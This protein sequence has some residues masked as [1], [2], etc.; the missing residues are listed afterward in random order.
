MELS[1]KAEEILEGLWV[2]L[3]SGIK[4]PQEL[5]AL[6]DDAA[7]KEL[8]KLGYVNATAET[9][10]LAEKG[11][12][13]AENSIRRHRLAERLMVDVLNIKKKLVDEVSCKFEHLLHKGVEDNV[14]ILLG[15]PKVCPHGKPIPSGACCKEAKKKPEIIVASLSR[16]EAKDRGKIAYIHTK[17]KSKL[18]KLMAMGALPGVT[19]N[20]IQKFP[21][22]VFQIGQSQFAVDKEL[23]EDIY[24]RLG[25]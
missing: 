18:Q 12:K 1:E 25:K 8:V 6:R 11:K 7:V 23:A 20:L 10:T 17:D 4:T 3:E 15:H 2:H 9:I 19:I 5:G 24:V 13:E 16:L 22:Y 14:C 21:S